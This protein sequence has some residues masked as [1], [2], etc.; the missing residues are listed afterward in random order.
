[1]SYDLLREALQATDL[2]QQPYVPQ[3]AP[4]QQYSAMPHNQQQFQQQFQQQQQCVQPQMNKPEEIYT[5]TPK[6]ELL[7]SSVLKVLEE[8]KVDLKK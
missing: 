1:M 5:P 3:Y 8:I 2:P 7:T 4:T 6:M